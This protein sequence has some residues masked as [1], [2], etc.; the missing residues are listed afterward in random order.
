MF[1]LAATAALVILLGAASQLNSTRLARLEFYVWSVVAGKAHGGQYAEINNVRIYYETYGSG[2]PVLV[3]HG[4]LGSSLDMHSQIQALAAA[5]FVIAPDS[6]AHGRS[7]DVELPISY[8]LMAEDM[9]Q[10]LDHLG[11][12]RT[13]VVGWSDGGIIGLDLAMHHPSRVH[14]LVVIGVNYDVD[15]LIKI[16]DLD[17]EVPPRPRFYT[18]NAP[19][20][21]HWPILYRKVVTMWRTQPDYTLDDLNKIKAPTLVIAG[22]FDAI[23]REHT[24]QLS[25]AIPGGRLE[26]IAGG[27]HSV[28]G[29]QPDIVNAD[30]VQFLDQR[31]PLQLAG[32]RHLRRCDP[33]R[34]RA[35]MGGAGP[36]RHAG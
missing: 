6:R 13:D 25:K 22:E 31:S 21:A 4:G 35:E 1:A 30:I 2:P 23:K 14:R 16:P 20:P 19:D 34:H 3:L 18:R 27:T 7:T 36:E 24:E 8:G 9:L 12:D 10:L 33:W 11:I 17:A 32:L 29:E 15:G 26:I 5:R 28:L